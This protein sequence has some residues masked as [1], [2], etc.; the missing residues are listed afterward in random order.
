VQVQDVEP[1]V[2]DQ[3]RRLRAEP[4]TPALA[5]RDAVAPARPVEKAAWEATGR[6]WSTAHA[7]RKRNESQ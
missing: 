5:D 1:V 2:E 4:L 6:A 7:T 3:P